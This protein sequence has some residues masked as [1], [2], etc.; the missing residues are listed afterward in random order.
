MS[1]LDISRVRNNLVVLGILFAI[2]FMI[3]SRADREK[4]RAT[5]DGL[6][7]LFGRKKE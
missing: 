4:A 2:G 6:K 5:I 3:Y 7:R 1:L